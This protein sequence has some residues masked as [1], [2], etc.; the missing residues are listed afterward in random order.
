MHYPLPR[1]KTR[2]SQLKRRLQVSLL[3]CS[4]RYTPEI[5]ILI[6]SNQNPIAWVSCDIQSLYPAVRSAFPPPPR[7]YEV[8]RE[9]AEDG[10]TWTLDFG[11]G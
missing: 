9:T 7:G 2:R 6:L 3:Q 4:S 5:R 10:N 8:K 11:L 1:G